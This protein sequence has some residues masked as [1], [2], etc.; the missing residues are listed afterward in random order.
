MSQKLR[1]GTTERIN[2][3]RGSRVVSRRTHISYDRLMQ[4]DSEAAHAD[5]M[6]ANEFDRYVRGAR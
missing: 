6:R 4:L 5:F 2:Y 3:R 1:F